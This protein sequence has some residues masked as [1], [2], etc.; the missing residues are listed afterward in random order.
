MRT[1]QAI[2][3]RGAHTWKDGRMA[4]VSTTKMPLRTGTATS[5]GRSVSR[6]TS[7]SARWPS[8]P[9]GEPGADDR[10]HQHATRRGRLK[11]DADA[12][13]DMIAE[14][15]AE[16]TKADGAAAPPRPERAARSAPPAGSRVGPARPR[17]TRRRAS[18][19]AGSARPLRRFGARS[20]PRGR[21]RSRR[22]RR[23]LLL[24]LAP[25]H[26]R[27]KAPSA[28]SARTAATLARS[29]ATMRA[30][31]P[32]SRHRWEPP[33]AASARKSAS[34]TSPNSIR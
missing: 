13:L 28:Y 32:L 30:F 12:V 31:S 16:I 1:G 25:I 5:S 21:S 9:S 11:E 10:D 33:S 20:P 8:S 3:D 14:R 23:G 24:A 19:S 2:I 18:S 6:A 4:W 29:G 7:R 22:H 26:R 15:A 17:S 27:R 34:P